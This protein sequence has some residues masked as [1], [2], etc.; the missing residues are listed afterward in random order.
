MSGQMQFNPYQQGPPLGL[1]G[2]QYHAQSHPHLG[3]GSLDSLAGLGIGGTSSS[4]ASQPSQAKVKMI[5]SVAGHFNQT[6]SGRGATYE[7]GETRLISVP[8]F[9]CYQELLEALQRLTDTMTLSHNSGTA[10]LIKYQLP[11]GNTFIDV[12]NDE[13]VTNMFEEWA[14]YVQSEG[15]TTSKLHIFEDRLRMPSSART[16]DR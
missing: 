4:L 3:P 9:C 16:A 13:D 15:K 11:G 8:N 6:A 1:P 7:G 14:D 2:P 5:C 10:Q 12:L